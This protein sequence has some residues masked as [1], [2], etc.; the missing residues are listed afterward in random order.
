MEINC[1]KLL[2]LV[3]WEKGLITENFLL[4]SYN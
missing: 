1:E 3:S 2:N 4:I